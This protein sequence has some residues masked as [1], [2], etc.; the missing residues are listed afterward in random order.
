MGKS[1]ESR[2]RVQA[3]SINCLSLQLVR[4][5]LEGLKARQRTCPKR[6]RPC[7]KVESHTARGSSWNWCFFIV[8]Q[9]NL[10]PDLALNLVAIKTKSRARGDTLATI[11]TIV[12]EPEQE[13]PKVTIR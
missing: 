12:T 3:N 5:D 2:D 7:L 1:L 11:K 13:E 4:S 6:V 10:A 9:V 8:F